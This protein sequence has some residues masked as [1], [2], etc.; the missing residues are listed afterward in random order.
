MHCD[1]IRL[2]IQNPI[3]ISDLQICLFAFTGATDIQRGRF[4]FRI[5]KYFP[6]LAKYRRIHECI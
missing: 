4:G 2:Q 3:R 1:L 6:T 5:T